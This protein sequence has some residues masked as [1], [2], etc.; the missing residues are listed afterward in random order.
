MLKVKKVW[1]D[2]IPIL[3]PILTS[4]HSFFYESKPSIGYGG[5]GL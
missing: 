1:S 2:Y 5:I 4:L 3:D